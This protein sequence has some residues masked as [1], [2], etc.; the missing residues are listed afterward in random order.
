MLDHE[1]LYQV[2]SSRVHDREGGKSGNKWR[3]S[4]EEEAPNGPSG[5]VEL[6]CGRI[7]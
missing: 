3:K 4:Q 5:R 7:I 2:K 6:N 1:A